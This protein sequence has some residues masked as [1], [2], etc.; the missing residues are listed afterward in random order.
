[1]QKDFG[2]YASKPAQF[3]RE[4]QPSR[5]LLE[6]DKSELEF[7]SESPKY[8]LA[9]TRKLNISPNDNIEMVHKEGDRINHTV[10]GTGTIV[11]VDAKNKIYVIKF[12]GFETARSISA[13]IKLEKI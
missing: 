2:D 10:F 4:S 7:A 13:H 9:Y 11:H 8:R 12:D 6:A 5:F 1:M 3:L